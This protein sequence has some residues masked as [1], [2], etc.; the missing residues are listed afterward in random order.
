MNVVFFFFFPLYFYNYFKF[1]KWSESFRPSITTSA[2]SVY[3]KKYQEFSVKLQVLNTNQVTFNYM[4]IFKFCK[5]FIRNFK[6]WAITHWLVFHSESESSLWSFQLL[7]RLLAISLEEVLLSRLSAKSK[8]NIVY[9][10]FRK[11]S[12][13]TKSGVNFS[14]Y[15]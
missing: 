14:M 15:S 6:K 5:E 4:G 13:H 10:Q 3:H 12:R 7:M 9:F 11:S 8:I 1:R 2:I